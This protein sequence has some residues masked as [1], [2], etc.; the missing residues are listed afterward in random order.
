MVKP[1]EIFFRTGFDIVILLCQSFGILRNGITA[2]AAAVETYSLF[3]GFVIVGWKPVRTSTGNIAPRFGSVMMSLCKNMMQTE[4]HH[5]I[6]NRF[7]AIKHH[8]FE[9]KVER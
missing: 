5:V 3:I 1:Q 8:L 7:M 6:H 4:R 2:F 9:L